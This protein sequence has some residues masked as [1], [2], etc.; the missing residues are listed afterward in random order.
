MPRK[1]KTMDANEA[2]ANVAYR[3][4]EVIAIYP[5]TPSPPWGAGRSLPAKSNGRMR[6][7]ATC[8]YIPT[9]LKL[10]AADVVLRDR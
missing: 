10:T 8:T 1:F 5:I 3:A 9:D 6:S 2:V 4:S 7:N